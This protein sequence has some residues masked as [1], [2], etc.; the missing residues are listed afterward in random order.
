M[1]RQRVLLSKGVVHDVSCAHRT[2][3]DDSNLLGTT[4][5]SGYCHIFL[6]QK[7]QS[8][9]LFLCSCLLHY[10]RLSVKCFCRVAVPL[11][12]LTGSPQWCTYLLYCLKYLYYLSSYPIQNR[13]ILLLRLQLLH[14][15]F[16]LPVSFCNTSSSILHFLYLRM[17]WLL[18]YFPP[19]VYAAPLICTRPFT[20]RYLVMPQ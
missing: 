13:P 18:R 4:A 12:H 17:L 5:S 11:A 15:S 20:G 2:N 7:L 14:F 3:A 1:V 19:A 6:W 9:C 16:S 8:Y 10:W